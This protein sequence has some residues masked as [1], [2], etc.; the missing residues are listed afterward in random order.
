[1]GW[2]EAGPGRLSAAWLGRVHPWRWAASSISAHGA[3][4][5]FNPFSIIRSDSNL[6]QT[7]KIQINL[8][9]SPKIMKLVPL[10]L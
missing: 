8:N 9:I 2:S 5:G 3:G 4:C 6:S 1:M 7:S 10:F